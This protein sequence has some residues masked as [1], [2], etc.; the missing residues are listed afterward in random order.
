MKSNTSW[1]ASFWRGTAALVLSSVSFTGILSP[2]ASHAMMAG[3][4]QAEEQI[5]AMM[6]NPV[7]LKKQLMELHQAMRSMSDSEWKQT[8]NQMA[9]LLQ[10]D[11]RGKQMAASFRQMA[12]LESRDMA[13]Q[14]LETRMDE[15]SQ[16]GL[17]LIFLPFF[18]IF[19]FV[20]LGNMDSDPRRAIL[21]M[22]LWI[23]LFTLDGEQAVQY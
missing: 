8:M 6:G 11:E 17:A 14:M 5:R 7:E 3:R 21:Y 4:S 15:L 18:L 20:I 9:D 16:N 1:T 13:L 12:E 19:Y 22:Y 10:K 23:C 2:V